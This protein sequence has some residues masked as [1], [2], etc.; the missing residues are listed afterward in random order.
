MRRVVI[1]GLGAVTPLAVGMFCDA[2]LCKFT[3]NVTGVRPTWKRLIDGHCGVVSIKD[4][5]PKFASLPSQ[6]AAVITAGLRTDGGWC[7]KEWL[8]PGVSNIQHDE[9][10]TKNKS[11]R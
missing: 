2:V 4:R 10:S 7:A 11:G 1:T 8:Q 5:N 9:D 6:V 3:H